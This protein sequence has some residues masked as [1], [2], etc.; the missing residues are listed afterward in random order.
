MRH[1][2]RFFWNLIGWKIIGTMPPDQKKFIIIAAPHTSNWDFLI[3]LCVRSLLGF[4]SNF[5]GKKSLFQWPF[6][7][8]FRMLGGYPVDRS[9]KNNLV[10]QVVALF[11]SKEK[12]ALALA[13]EGTRKAVSDW[14][15]GFYYIA[16]QANVPIVRTKFDIK[17]K[18][19]TIFP[20]YWPTGDISTD[21]VQIKEVFK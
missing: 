7:W 16:V 8:L 18:C 21:M 9:N 15:T 4:E 19:V 5:L 2:I 20:P 6:G 3:G 17:N 14:K 10:D 1:I 12:F 11:N 13:P